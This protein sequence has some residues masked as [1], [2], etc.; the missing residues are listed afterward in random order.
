MKFN[1]LML[2]LIC[3]LFN[4]GAFFSQ[5][6]LTES[7]DCKYFMP[8]SHNRNINNV[9]TRDKNNVYKNTSAYRSS[10]LKL[11][12]DSTFI[13][14]DISKVAFD[15]STGKYTLE[16]DL[17]TL[18]W[19]SL[20]TYALIEK[21]PQEYTEQVMFKKPRPFKIEKTVF[22]KQKDRFTPYRYHTDVEGLE[23]LYKSDDLFN[24]HTGLY[25]S[26]TIGYNGSGKKLLITSKD[27]SQWEIPCE[28]IWGFAIHQ[29][30]NIKVYR[31]VP[32]GMNPFGIPGI[33]VVQMDKLIIYNIGDDQGR[34]Y[35]SKDL[36]SEIYPLTMKE[37]KKLFAEDKEFL[38]KL[39]R[40]FGLHGSIT[41][42]DAY[43]NGYKFIELYRLYKKD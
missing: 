24:T 4:T 6:Y 27:K 33:R 39:Y 5:A 15:V 21:E 36:N 42:S 23:L 13:Y 1:F 12:D 43:F 19:D 3:C 41:E 37:V 14:Y 10:I 28:N 35:F 2:C 29:D 7:R 18:N 11:N 16:D 32:R 31:A 38:F 25:G 40:E 20:K 9:L 34:S 26:S 30:H 8:Y 17:L 22:V